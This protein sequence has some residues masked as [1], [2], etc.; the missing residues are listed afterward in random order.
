MTVTVGDKAPEFI[1]YNTLKESVRLQDYRGKNVIVLFFP[2]AFSSICTVELCSMRDH[3]SEYND[4]DT[5]VVG[6]S[7]DSLYSLKKFKQEHH[8]NFPLLSD[9]NKDVSRSYGSLY[10]TF[11]YDMKGVS[12]RSAFLIN[13]LGFVKYAEVL[14]KPSD[15]PNFDAIKN[16]LQE[17]SLSR[18]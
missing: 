9:F 16:T 14:E 3:L 1:L 10:E 8:L 5:E 15:L 11:A 13:S 4:L 12:K 17:I 6:I 2:L 18:A 7:V